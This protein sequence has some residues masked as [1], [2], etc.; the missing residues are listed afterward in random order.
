MAYLPMDQLLGVGL[1]WSDPE[2][3]RIQGRGPACAGRG[4][5]SMRFPA[6]WYNAFMNSERLEGGRQ[7]SGVAET[8]EMHPWMRR[9]AALLL[10]FVASLAMAQAGE[11]FNTDF[12]KG[13]FVKL[14]WIAKGPWQILDYG[15]D[16]PDLANNPGKVVRLPGNGQETGLLTKK[17]KSI[18]NPASLTLTFD[19][20]YGWGAKDHAHG[21]TILILDG[22]GNGYVFLNMRVKAI[23]G[24]QWAQV[25]QYEWPEQLNWAPAEIDTTQASVVDGGGL[26]TYTITRNASGKWTFNCNGWKGGPLTFTNT[27]T[28]TFS[29]VVLFSKPNVDD[30]VYNKIKLKTTAK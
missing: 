18:T 23:W 17:F 1:A 6:T 16:K 20:G 2:S 7:R 14:G 11:I 25:A 30:I 10:A 15:A 24:A 21:L 12:S 22:E 27:T 3:Q 28:T 19:G 4:G 29:Q 13:D 26:K 9:C 8:I 5:N